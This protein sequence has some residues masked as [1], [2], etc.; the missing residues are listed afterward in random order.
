MH[1]PTLLMIESIRKYVQIPILG[2]GG[3]ASDLDSLVQTFMAGAV[4]VESV[5]PFYFRTPN[6]MSV[7]SR[8]KELIDQLKQY[9]GDHGM[10]SPND[11]YQT[12]IK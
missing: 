12:R 3:C 5:T 9:L 1:A 7:L 2:T 11:L 4:A 8:A 6:E 10:E